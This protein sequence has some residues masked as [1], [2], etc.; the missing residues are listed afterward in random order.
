MLTP[1]QLVQAGIF[2]E[3]DAQDCLLVESGIGWLKVH[4]TL[5]LKQIDGSTVMQLPAGAKLFLQQYCD[6]M[7]RG[8]IASE[9]IEGLSQSFTADGLESLLIQLAQNLLPEYFIAFRFFPKVQQWKY[10]SK[11]GCCDD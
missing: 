5:Q 10:S 8:G 6:V 1:E 7:Q 11:G 9:Q 4:T 3:A 2:M